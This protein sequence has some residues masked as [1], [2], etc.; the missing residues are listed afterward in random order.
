MKA[1]LKKLFA[2][3]AVSALVAGTI[4][5]PAFSRKV[6]QGVRVGG[7]EVGGMTYI[8]AARAVRGGIADD[9]KGRQLAVLSER[10]SYT[11][12]YPEIGFTDNLQQV[13]ASAARGG[14]YPVRVRYHL[15]GM[16]GIVSGICAD[17][18]VELQE[19][20]ALFNADEGQP[21]EYRAGCAGVVADGCALE[22]D[23]RAA[24]ALRGFGEDFAPVRVKLAKTMPTVT[25]EQVRERTARLSAYTTYFDGENAPR[26]HNIRLAA[27]MISG[28]VLA[29]GGQFSFN[30]RVGGRT[31]ERG[32][33]RAKVILNGEYT[34]GVGGGVCQMST[35]LYNAA[36]LAGFT[37]TEYHPHSLAVGY[38][39]PSRDA[40]VSGTS[41]DL[42]FVNTSKCPAY[43]RV[44]TGKNYVRCEIYGLAD[45]AEYSLSSR[46]C[47]EGREGTRS[48]AYLTVTRGGES[49]TK[50]IRRD[51]YLPAPPAV[52][53]E[54]TEEQ[55]PAAN[56]GPPAVQD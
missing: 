16:D 25:D 45:G 21:F 27:K 36:L 13:L 18:F 30:G 40:M 46:V 11:F 37:V 49:T 43:I 8:R 24:L 4:F 23:I 35:T 1:I 3:F 33:M 51:R 10:N 19:P 9:L 56:D 34:Y 17:E 26:A 47:A 32:F 2:L 52:R 22:R 15:N 14:S 42:K 12:S 31:A 54:P 48:E 41:C 50:L 53:Q 5:L 7:I 28:C 29:A 38:V 39:S 20:S 6:P 44:L 55:E